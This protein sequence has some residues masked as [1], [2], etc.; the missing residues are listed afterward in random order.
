[1]QKMDDEGN[2]YDGDGRRTEG[3]MATMTKSRMCRTT[4]TGSV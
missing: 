3:L 2:A 1:M 4:R